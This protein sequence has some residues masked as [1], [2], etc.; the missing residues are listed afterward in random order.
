[1]YKEKIMMG[2]S[3]RAFVKGAFAA[4]TLATL[5]ARLGGEGRKAPPLAAP[6]GGGQPAA[7]QIN[8]IA[9]GSLSLQ[10]SM[11][12]AGQHLLAALNPNENYL[13]YFIMKIGRDYRA[14][15]EFT[16]PAH[17]IGRWLDAM[18]RLENAT[19]FAIPAKL[20]AAMLANLRLFFDNPDNLCLPPPQYAQLGEPPN[21]LEIH[22]MREGLLALNALAR[23]RGNRWALEHSH[24]MMETIWRVSRANGDWDYDGLEAA[25]H[26]KRPPRMDPTQSHGRLIEALV[27][28]YET[29]G[30]PLALKLANRFAEYHLENTTS[31]DG[32]LN[33]AS[34]ADH[35][36]SYLGTLRGLVLFGELTNQRQYIER[37]ASTYRTYV[38][39]D[40]IKPSGVISHGMQEEGNAEPASAGDVVQ[41]GLW[42]ARHGYTE[43]LEDVERL[44]RCRLLP[45]QIV[46]RPGLKPA[47]QDGSDAHADLD[48]RV[49]GG[50]AG[51][52]EPYWGRNPATDITCA[53]LHT[54]VDVYQ[55]VAV[56]SPMGLVV[57]FHFDYEDDR[58]RISS[59]QGEKAKVTLVPKI[60]QNIAIRIPA[61]T[62]QDSVQL[63]VNGQPFNQTRIGRFAY[64]PREVF[65]APILL[66]YDLP[67]RKEVERIAG[68]DYTLTWKGNGIAGISPNSDFLP[69]Y[70]TAAD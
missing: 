39:G 46:Q 19:G 60:R 70:P 16:W 26:M 63:T 6:N 17:N 15:Y 68:V 22:S 38:L 24:R 69:L 5:P 10:K 33:L 12:M 66:Q 51:M 56:P 67:V 40:L 32:T 42:L 30:D 1:L 2:I 21:Q 45:S 52:H 34:K 54:L 4:S 58:I 43:F 64:I 7:P 14:S 18:L 59:E 44:V 29:S 41:L 57:N 37:V 11:H 13:P 25:R 50:Y 49:V 62:T 35:T 8:A 36:H 3:R 47:I 23:Y 20:E 55:H 65:P 9:P 48:A 28:F 53:V 31:A 27:W 61:W